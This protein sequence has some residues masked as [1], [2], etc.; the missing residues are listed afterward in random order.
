MET[1][2]Q[3]TVRKARPADI[4]VMTTLIHE[5]VRGLSRGFYSD[6]Q[7]ESA[8][9]YVFGVDT[10]LVDDGTYFCV[11]A[12][13]EIVGCGGWSMR[14]THYG[15]DHAKHEPDTLDRPGHRPGT[16]PGVLRP[17]RLGPPRHRADAARCLRGGGAC[18][19]LQPA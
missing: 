5:S 4:P 17:S 14:Q 9:R 13:S 8:I 16:H 10:M 18:G 12:G 15:G 1:T 11:E 6:Q 19:G 2:V 3:L 7:I